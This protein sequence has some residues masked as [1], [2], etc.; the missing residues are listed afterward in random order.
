MAAQLSS[1]F[2]GKSIPFSVSF[3][4]ENGNGGDGA[5]LPTSFMQLVC[6]AGV[7]G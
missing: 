5:D 2:V 3:L 4:L 6:G 7:G 1:S